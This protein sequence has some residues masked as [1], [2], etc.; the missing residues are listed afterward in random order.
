MFFSLIKGKN[1]IVKR[2]D[3]HSADETK[4]TDDFKVGYKILLPFYYLIANA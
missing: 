2:V 1:S 4:F 3:R